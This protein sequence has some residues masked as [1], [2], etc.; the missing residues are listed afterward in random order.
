MT[1][2]SMVIPTE[3]WQAS[4][5]RFQRASKDFIALRC[6]SQP[7]KY[8]HPG[9]GYLELSGCFKLVSQSPLSAEFV[10]L[11]AAAVTGGC[12]GPEAFPSIMSF[13][14]LPSGVRHLA[15]R[16]LV[17]QSRKIRQSLLRCQHSN[18]MVEA[19]L[20]T[21]MTKCTSGHRNPPKLKNL[22]TNRY[23]KIM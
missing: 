9:F 15:R 13:N 23:C 18:W 2:H 7:H 3:H 6:P 17:Q 11:V 8:P 10:Y 20:R 4:F 12:W 5:N 19:G 16:T 14:P 1:E 21:G 22:P